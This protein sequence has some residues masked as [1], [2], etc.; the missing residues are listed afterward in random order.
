MLKYET[1][2][3]SYFGSLQ[4]N[5]VHECA[6]KCPF[7]ND[8]HPSMSVN[9]DNGMF[10]CFTCNAEGSALSFIRRR[11]NLDFNSALKKLQS[12][13][14][15]TDI[16]KDFTDE[17]IVAAKS[18]NESDYAYWRSRGISKETIDALKVGK[19]GNNFVFPYYDTDGRI[20]VRKVLSPADKKQTW[21]KPAKV[22]AVRLYN[23]F[24][25]EEARKEHKILLVCEGEKDTLAAKEMEFRAVGVSGVRGFQHELAPLFSG[26]E[27]ALVFDNDAEG[28]T[29]SENVAGYLGRYANV[30]IVKWNLSEDG[31]DVNQLLMDLGKEKATRE[32]NVLIANAQTL[33]KRK[34]KANI[35]LDLLSESESALLRSIHVDSFID[36]YVE[37]ASERTDAPLAFHYT[38]ALTLVSTVIGGNVAVHLSTGLM[39]PNIWALLLGTSAIYRKTTSLKLGVNI[40][41][42]VDA[43]AIIASDFSPEGLITELAT[44]PKG[45]IWR[46][47]FAGFLESATKRDYMS[48]TKSLL[49]R[50]FDGNSFKRKLRKETLEIVDPYVVLLSAAVD[51]TIAENLT[52]EDFYSGFAGR[53]L[54]VRPDKIRER[55]SVTMAE[56][57]LLEEEGALIDYLRQIKINF[58]PTPTKIILQVGKNLYECNAPEHVEI[59]IEDKVLNRWNAM[60]KKLEEF[61]V[62]TSFP[63]E[64]GPSLTRLGDYILKVAI[65]FQAAE[66]APSHQ[67]LKV[68]YHNVIRAASFIQSCVRSTIDIISDA[69]GRK[70]RYNMERVLA[71]IKKQQTIS[72]S[73]LL[74]SCQELTSTDLNIIIDTLMDRG[75]I[76]TNKDSQGARFYTYIEPS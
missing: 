44:N 18:L 7:H 9:I 20:R 58:T 4:P 1:L 48:G 74:W 47:E 39:K 69:V 19:E 43:D 66:T 67:K 49:M 51:K 41:Q 57:K 36:H 65:C 26:V 22:D 55:K 17:H 54:L 72:R 61:S 59:E 45:M 50:I 56:T 10:K 52:T 42:K 75:A 5:D 28:L 60:C 70:G 53:I 6:V 13:I 68:E 24:D 34:R 71:I 12:F 31:Y 3:S 30:R 8:D 11:D 40:L 64:I 27:V 14:P 32:L 33:T 37:Y 16:V 23:I 76:V 15:I 63:E 73:K 62:T 25:I 35:H 21:W 29:A 2:Y 38:V 46:D